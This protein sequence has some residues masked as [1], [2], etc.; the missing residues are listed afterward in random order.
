MVKRLSEEIAERRPKRSREDECCPEQRH[1]IEA[2]EIVRRSDCSNHSSC[3]E[4]ALQK[5]QSHNIDEKVTEG[6]AE[7]V[8]KQ[9]RQPEQQLNVPTN[10]GVDPQTTLAGTFYE[11]IVLDL[12]LPD[13]DGLEWLQEIRRAGLHTPVLILS[14]RDAPQT[15]VEGLD[16]GADDYLAKPFEVEILVARIRAL[17]R[18]PSASHGTVLTEGNVSFDTSAREARV[19]GDLIKIGRRELDS[20]ELLLRRT[21]RV[22]PKEAFQDAIYPVGEEVASNAIEVLIHRLRKRI[23][24]RGG[25]VEIHTIRGVGYMLRE[26]AP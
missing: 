12:G 15:I 25:N 23:R 13:G 7:R 2:G 24:D 8:R 19:G 10:D 14:A 11:T 22:V 6:S 20:L 5:S 9:N 4:R 21:G 3:D 16:F 18:R 17:L 1:V 26:R